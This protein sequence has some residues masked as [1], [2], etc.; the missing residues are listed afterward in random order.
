MKNPINPQDLT[1]IMDQQRRAYCYAI[2][3][4]LLWSTVA[5]AFKIT[6]QYLSPVELLFWS[7]GVSLLVLS[8]LVLVQGRLEQVKKTTK[9]EYLRSAALGLL[10]P[11]FYYLIL[12]EAYNLLPAQE[13]QPLNQT[14]GVVLPLLSIVIL[15]QR[16]P[17]KSIFALFVSFFGVLIL[18]THGNILALEFSNLT[19]VILAVGSAFIWALFWIYNVSDERDEVTKLFL[20]FL[21]GFIYMVPAFLI[22]EGMSFPPLL[23]FAGGVYVGVFEMG[24]TFVLWLKALQLSRTTAQVT[25]LI[26]LV[27]FISLIFIHYTVGEEILLS[28]VAGLVFIISGILIQRYDPKSIVKKITGH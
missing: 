21:F 19:G 25:I 18:S 12:F 20:N 26:Y 3:V 10:N 4:V 15:G 24:V 14:W 8:F 5:S 6:L 13:A 9:A 11:F 28:T 7:S 16:I 22:L 1:C 23:G 2:V 17:A 27:P